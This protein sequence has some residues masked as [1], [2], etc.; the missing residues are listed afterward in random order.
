M[1]SWLQSLSFH[2]YDVRTNE[3]EDESFDEDVPLMD[4]LIALNRAAEFVESGDQG[5]T[6]SNLDT[7]AKAATQ[8]LNGNNAN[9]N[10][11]NQ[12]TG[13]SENQSA[14]SKDKIVN[15]TSGTR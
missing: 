4:G 15:N 1:K 9:S 8:A 3:T 10:G 12:A 2:S 7:L 11:G 6:A 13:G 14:C 5:T